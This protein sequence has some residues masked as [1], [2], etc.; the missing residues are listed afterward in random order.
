[1]IKLLSMDVPGIVSVIFSLLFFVSLVEGTQENPALLLETKQIKKA[2]ELLEYNFQHA[3]SKEAKTKVAF[4]LAKAYLQ[5]GQFVKAL[6]W[7]QD[8]ALY[9]HK[10][11]LF[12][13]N[14]LEISGQALIEL[15]QF[16]TAKE[17]L[18]E[19][20]TFFCTFQKEKGETSCQLFF[21]QVPSGPSLKKMAKLAEEQEAPPFIEG[22]IW[23][24]N[25]ASRLTGE[26]PF[27]TPYEEDWF[28]IPLKFQKKIINIKRELVAD[29]IAKQ[30]ELLEA[31]VFCPSN[32]FSTLTQHLQKGFDY[33]AMAVNSILE[34]A[35]PFKQVIPIQQ[36]AIQEFEKAQQLWD[37]LE[38]LKQPQEREKYQTQQ[39]NSQRLQEMF[40]RDEEDQELKVQSFG[41][42]VW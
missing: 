22:I 24:Q 23:H 6:G 28:E 15:G 29:V 27:T 17:V 3:P 30:T 26:L 21:P 20:H 37:K 40:S 19:A 11:P 34:R 5:D 7:L 16:N 8:I 2:L 14:V 38:T 25:I 13:A 42:V 12:I 10:D 18:E 39:Q 33:A 31:G 4:E 36:L 9:N 1:M 32:F 35:V 41:G